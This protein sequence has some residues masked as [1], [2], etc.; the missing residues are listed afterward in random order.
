MNASSASSLRN[1]AVLP[2]MIPSSVL[3]LGLLPSADHSSGIPA[4]RQ[5]SAK[6][7]PISAGH[8]IASLIQATEQ[9]GRRRSRAESD[10][11]AVCTSP[12]SVRCGGERVVTRDVFRVSLGR[13]ACRGYTIEI[14]AGGEVG[15]R[16][17]IRALS[18]DQ[19]IVRA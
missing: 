19:R 9:S 13:L 11:A 15:D 2:A 7:S 6:R 8:G 14:A 17:R 16:D 5:P 10:F 3:A 1:A 4:T 12:L 18:T